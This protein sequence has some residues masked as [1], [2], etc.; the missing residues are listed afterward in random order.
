[1]SN[2]TKGILLI[3]CGTIFWGTGG[4]VAEILFKDYGLIVNDYVKLR[5]LVS[6]VLLLILAS[7]RKQPVIAPFLS[8]IHI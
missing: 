4:T 2:Q 5:L 7:I 1:M 8:L 3:I 6:G